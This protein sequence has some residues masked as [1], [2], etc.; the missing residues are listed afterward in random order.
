MGIGSPSKPIDVREGVYQVT[1]FADLL[2]VTLRK[3]PADFKP[4]TRYRDYALSQ[5]LFHWE[6]QGRTSVESATGQR[7][8]QHRE[9][10]LE[11]L[12]FVRENT[13]TADGETEPFVFLGPVT[14]GTHSGSRPIAITWELK[15]PMPA[16]FLV[17]ARAVA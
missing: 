10:G 4:T 11:M 6:S 2:F 17:A 8:I 7:Y 3:D 9:R 1:G 13:E 15:F 5:T 16:D 14:Y 12:L